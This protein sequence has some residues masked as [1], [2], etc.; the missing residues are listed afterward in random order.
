M[1][2]HVEG[3]C[4]SVRMT[5]TKRLRSWRQPSPLLLCNTKAPNCRNKKAFKD[6]CHYAEWPKVADAVIKA[7]NRYRIVNEQDM[8]EGMERYLGH[9][10]DR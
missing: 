3:H 7:Y 6:L 2:Q 5:V 1:G 8:R 9:H 4:A 10:T